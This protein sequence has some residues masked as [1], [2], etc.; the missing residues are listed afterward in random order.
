MLSGKALNTVKACR[1]CWMCRHLCPV[2]LATGKESNTPRAKALLLDIE[3]KGRDL[4]KEYAEDMF[5][6]CLCA[7]CAAN[8]ETG[9]E[10]PVFIREARRNVVAHGMAPGYV[11]AVIEKLMKE[12]A[13]PQKAAAEKADVLVYIGAHGKAE[14]K[15][16]ADAFGSVLTKAGVPYMTLAAEPADGNELY[17]LIGETAEVKQQAKACADAINASG[18]KQVVVLNPSA[19]RMFK[20]E[21]PAWGLELSAEVVTAT[22]FAAGLLKEGKLKMKQAAGLVTYHDPCRLARDLEETEPARE[23]IRAMGYELKEMIQSKKLTKCCGGIVLDAHSPNLA[24]LTASGRLHD[25]DRIDVPVM[26]TACPGCSSVLRKGDGKAEVK[27]L[28]V[29]LDENTL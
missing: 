28:F 1:F 3:Q 15:E 23:L 9:Y 5:Q 12:G 6:C 2:G 18:A 13:E 25:A 4:M 20:Q 11:M 8:C 26:L 24:K 22:A 29:L 27:D 16:M 17:D 14:A 21:Y 7:S 10:P 19:A